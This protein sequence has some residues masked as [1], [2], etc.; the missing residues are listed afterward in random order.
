MMSRRGL[1]VMP[2]SM[3]ELRSR[4][5]G[6]QT[7]NEETIN[8]RLKTAEKEMELAPQYDYIVVNDVVEEAAGRLKAILEAEKC[9]T[10][11]I[12]QF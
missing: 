6:R 7:E 4:L 1:L 3:E 12:D 5:C 9:R 2:P 11:R 10:A 8:N